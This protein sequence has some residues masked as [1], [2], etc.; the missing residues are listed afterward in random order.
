M[1]IFFTKGE[2]LNLN[3]YL[4]VSI[5]IYFLSFGIGKE[6]LLNGLILKVDLFNYVFVLLV[7]SSVSNVCISRVVIITIIIISGG[8]IIIKL[9]IIFYV[10]SLKL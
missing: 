8:K 6:L 9:L 7:S 10:F 4:L 3:A 1:E 5:L 2:I